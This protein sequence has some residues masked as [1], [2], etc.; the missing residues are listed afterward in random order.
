MFV[1]DR[2]G[3]RRLV[4]RLAAAGLAELVGSLRIVMVGGPRQ[5][6]KTTLLRQYL[7]APTE[8]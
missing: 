3:H 2:S 4:P 1:D 8:R 5:V 7:A 6:G